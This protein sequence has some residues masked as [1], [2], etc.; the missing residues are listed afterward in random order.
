M[1]GFGEMPISKVASAIVAQLTLR[2]PLHS[3]V[4]P[5]FISLL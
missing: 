3:P 1:S 4:A 2:S 5:K